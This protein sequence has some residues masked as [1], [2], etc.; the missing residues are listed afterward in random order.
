M[1][2]LARNK[3]KDIVNPHKSKYEVIYDQLGGG[4]GYEKSNSTF[5]LSGFYPLSEINQQFARLTIHP[6]ICV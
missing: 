1:L 4:G 2:I 6:T 3:Q 5:F